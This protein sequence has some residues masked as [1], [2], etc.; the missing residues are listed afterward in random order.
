MDIIKPR[1]NVCNQQPFLRVVP[2]INENSQPSDLCPC[3]SC[4]NLINE[5]PQHGRVGTHPKATRQTACN[6][7]DLVQAEV[8]PSLGHC[9]TGKLAPCRYVHLSHES[10]GDVAALYPENIGAAFGFSEKHTQNGRR[11]PRS[12]KSSRKEQG[13]RTTKRR[14]APC[15]RRGARFSGHHEP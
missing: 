7:F 15:K 10:S 13:R 14:R 9:A 3:R 8:Q 6:A 1:V 12:L 5:V 11:P 4:L 2:S